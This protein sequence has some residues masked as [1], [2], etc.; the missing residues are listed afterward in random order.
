MALHGEIKINSTTLV[1]WEA[2][3]LGPRRTDGQ[4]DL[5]KT[6]L[7]EGNLIKRDHIEHRYEDGAAMLAA[8]VLATRPSMWPVPVPLPH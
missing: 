2:R 3:R 1:Y 8:R 6:L 5:Y 7:R 4:P